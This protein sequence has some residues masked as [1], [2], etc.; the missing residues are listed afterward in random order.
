MNDE[1]TLFK[2]ALE[3]YKLGHGVQVTLEQPHTNKAHESY[4]SIDIWD[5]DEGLNQYVLTDIIDLESII[6]KYN[7]DVE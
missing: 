4:I 6:L 1:M 5:K 2:V 7:L 3:I